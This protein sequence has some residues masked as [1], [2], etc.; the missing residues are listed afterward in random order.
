M[1]LPLFL[2]LI[3]N[4]IKSMNM[5]SWSPKSDWI[6]INGLGEKTHGQPNGIPLN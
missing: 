4:T 1:Y 2:L 3:K 6:T 5:K